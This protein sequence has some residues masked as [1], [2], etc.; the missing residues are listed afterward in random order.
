[1]VPSKIRDS[2]IMTEKAIT[3][4]IAGHRER[5]RELRA[6]FEERNVDLDDPRAIE[7]HFWAWSQ[8]DAAVL[9]RTLYQMGFLLRLLAPAPGEND[10]DRWSV[11][12]GTKIPLSQAL[13]NELTEKLVKLAAAEDSV[14]DG[15]GTSV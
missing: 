1:M 5:N 9:G 8:R 6:K 3:K 12:A 13:G 7:F 2:V 11:E 10:P 15:W 14:F 4:E